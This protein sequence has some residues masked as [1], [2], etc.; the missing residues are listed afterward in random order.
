MVFPENADL[1]V[2]VAEGPAVDEEAQLCR[3]S[4]GHCDDRREMETGCFLSVVTFGDRASRLDDQDEANSGHE[5]AEGNVA[6]GFYPCFP[7]GKTAGIDTFDRTI[8]EDEG[9]IAE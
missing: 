9:K 1:R 8:A 2:L 4:D 5:E 3:E 7:A 6:R